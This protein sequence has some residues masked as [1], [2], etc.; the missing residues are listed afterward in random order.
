M[1]TR[2]TEQDGSH[3]PPVGTFNGRV[4]RP[5]APCQD[6]LDDTWVVRHPNMS[7][8]SDA[9]PK[10][11]TWHPTRNRCFWCAYDHDYGLSPGDLMNYVHTFG[12]MG[13]KNNMKHELPLGFK[14]F[15]CE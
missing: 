6:E 5:T 9:K 4:I 10:I 1:P 8:T 3:S 13:H 15:V 14:G 11:A 7:D 2:I 12:Y